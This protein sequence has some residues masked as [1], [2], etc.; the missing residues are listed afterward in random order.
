MHF[1]L[2]KKSIYTLKWLW[3]QKNDRS[4]EALSIFWSAFLSKDGKPLYIFSVKHF[5]FFIKQWKTFFHNGKLS[6][7]QGKTSIQAFGFLCF[8]DILSLGEVFTPQKRKFA[9]TVSLQNLE[10]P[11]GWYTAHNTADHTHLHRTSALIK[12]INTPY[13]HRIYIHYYHFYFQRVLR[14]LAEFT[15]CYFPTLKKKKKKI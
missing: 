3:K 12:A 14:S 11:W 7:T 4:P 5:F 6:F 10:Q 2:F 13:F 1:T 9:K 8:G 15:K